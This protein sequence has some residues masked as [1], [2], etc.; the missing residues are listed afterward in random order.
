[1]KNN[2]LKN[3]KHGFSLVEIVVAL[4]IISCIMAA[5]APLITKKLKSS[6][7]TIAISEVSAKCSK[8]SSDCTLCY[9]EKCIICSKSCAFSEYKDNNNCVCINCN[10]FSENCITCNES[11]CTKCNLGYGIKDGSCEICPKGYYSNGTTSCLPCEAGK[12]QNEEGK[13]TCKPCEVSKYQDE[14]GKDTCK[15]PP[16]GTYQDLPAQST[17]K[18]CPIDY[19][20]TNGIKT[21]C[22]AGKGADE[23][24]G[25]CSLCSSKIANCA[26][27]SNLS[28]CT[29]C[30]S[31]Y[32]LNSTKTCSICALDNYCDGL[33][34]VQCP[35]GQYANIGASSCSTCSSKWANCTACTS[36]GCSACKENYTLK[37]GKCQK[38][39]SQADC[40]KLAVP[41]L[42]FV[43]LG[44]D[45]THA[46]C[47]QK[48]NEHG[49]SSHW[50]STQLN[51]VPYAGSASGCPAG[52]A[53]RFHMHSTYGY[54]GT[55]ELWVMSGVY[56][57]S[58]CTGIG[59]GFRLPNYGELYVFAT[60][61]AKELHLCTGNYSAEYEWCPRGGNCKVDGTN[62]PDCVPF[63]VH[64]SDG[65]IHADGTT[66][67]EYTVHHYTDFTGIWNYKVYVGSVRCVVDIYK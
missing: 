29:K 13:N 51:P 15:T 57:D 2:S 20:C 25:S 47:V 18:I 61:Y 42:L 60:K 48:N 27:C 9:P 26:E 10:D 32:Y 39:L 34:Q 30:N 35:S 21:Q 1:M 7:V 17:T 38:L 14:E 49:F 36:S 66:V 50:A 62:E 22:S 55:R 59:G 44:T 65:F 3:N 23:G 28:E 19:Y 46:L 31:G 63:I 67:E 5:L 8:F 16:D 11:S 12:Y 6:N 4:I 45:D 33:S 52:W 37:D 24:S 56:A 54:T 64:G 41:N 58:T 53:C 40:D 43:S